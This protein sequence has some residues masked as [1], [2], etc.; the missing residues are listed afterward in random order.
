MALCCS[1]PPLS[2]C[3][4]VFI[5]HIFIYAWASITRTVAQH[6]CQV[7]LSNSV[8]NALNVCQGVTSVHITVSMETAYVS[9]FAPESTVQP[10][11]L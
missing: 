1:R 10:V 6:H 4:D 5:S 9:L 3:V 2:G 7:S 8:H 11:K